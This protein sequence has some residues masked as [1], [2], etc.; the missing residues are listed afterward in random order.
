MMSLKIRSLAIVVALLC[1]SAYGQY[2]GYPVPGLGGLKA[3]SQ[4]DPGIYVTIPLFYDAM[5]S[6]IGDAQGNT[7]AKNLGVD[8]YI[9]GTP[10]LG[11]TTNLKIFGANYG[12]SALALVLQGVI[13]LARPNFSRDSAWGFGDM[14]VQPIILGWHL[15]HADI[16]TAY[17]FWAPTGGNHGLHQWQNEGSLGATF[18]LDKNKKWNLST[19]G[20]FDVP[21]TKDNTDI[22]VGKLLSLQGGLGWSFLKGAGNV[23]AAYFAQWKLTHDSGSAIPP[24]LPITNGR[25][26]G[27][28]PQI[29]MPVFAK[30]TNVGLL[31]FAYMWLPGPKTYFQGQTL[32]ATFTFAKLTPAR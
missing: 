23:G 21:L 19:M 6:G 30:G 14:Y 8:L 2:V 7:I 17:G 1:T 24:A 16:T 28:G 9:F 13:S 4:P 20:F 3:G 29:Q 5:F 25:V 22:K 31:G 18:Y 27:V 10:A 11:V 15:N 26:F 32:M 12:F